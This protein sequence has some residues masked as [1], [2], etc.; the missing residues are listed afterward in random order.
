MLTGDFYRDILLTP[1][2]KGGV[3]YVVSGYATATMVARHMQDMHEK[4]LS[5]VEIRLIVG[6]TAKE[7]ILDTNHKGICALVEKSGDNKFNCRYIQDGKPPV[8]AKTYAWFNGKTPVCGY[9]GSANY[10]QTAFFGRQQEAMDKSD[11]REIL[12]YYETLETVSVPCDHSD[13]QGLIKE[14]ADVKTLRQDSENAGELLANRE[15][16]TTSL[17]NKSGD[18]PQRSGLNWGQR[19]EESRDPNQGYIRLPSEIY[20]GNFF[21]ET[22]HVFALH[23]DDGQMML[24]A[25]AQSGGKAIHSVESNS[26]VGEYFRRRLNVPLGAPV[27][28]KHL[29][30]YGRTDVTFYKIEEES[31]LMDFSPSAGKTACNGNMPTG[32]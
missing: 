25:R 5:G 23:T 28:L 3:L 11:P 29:Q 13:A 1:A 20:K 14:D 8:H 30:T 17:L 18:L 15:S 16:V 26:F 2:K 22:G 9:V 7:G 32:K 31:Y 24:C 27:L 4:K 21:P 6:M 10:T 12:R 19:P